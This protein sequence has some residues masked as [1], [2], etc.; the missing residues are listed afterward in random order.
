MKILKSKILD[1]CSECLKHKKEVMAVIEL[2]DGRK[3]CA[4]HTVK[5]ALNYYATEY[6]KLSGKNAGLFTEKVLVKMVDE[7]IYNIDS[8]ALDEFNILE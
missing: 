1:S 7:V 5:E 8:A 2:K 4:L 3:F 6:F